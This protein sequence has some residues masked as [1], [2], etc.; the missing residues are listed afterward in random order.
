LYSLS[1]GSD[2]V[3]EQ[4]TFLGHYRISVDD[5]GAP[6]ERGRTGSAITYEATDERSGES[7][8]LTLIP[9]ASIDPA[10]QEQFEEQAHAATRI[11][12]VNIAKVF[13]FGREKEYFV[14]VAELLQGEPL[15]SWIAQHGPMP[16]D[17]V[18]RAAEQIVSVLSTARFHKLAHCAIQPSNLIIVPG[19]TPE[20]TWPFVK[21]LNFSLAGLKSSPESSPR[22]ESVPLADSRETDAAHGEFEKPNGSDEREESFS[23]ASQFASPEE[24]QHQTVDF[25]SEVYSLG[26]T[27]YFMLT[28]AVLPPEVRLR[29]RELSG[30]PKTL[31]DL[32]ANMLHRD[33]DRRPKDP[34]VLA[35]MIRGCL[36]KIERRQSLAR[37][38]GIPLAGVSRRKPRATLTPFAQVLRGI[39]VFASILLAAGVLGAFLLPADL[40]PFWHRTAAK[41]MI[42]VPIGVP[43]VSS[44]ATPQAVNAAPI[45]ANQPA[46]DAAPSPTE[47]QTPPPAPEQE[48]T[49]NAGFAAAT[50]PANQPEASPDVAAAGPENSAQAQADTESASSSSGTEPPPATASQSASSGKKKSV[51]SAT[52]RARV[53]RD[54]NYSQRRHSMR[55]TRARV[56]GIT[57]DGRLIFRLSS[58]RTVIVTPGSEDEDE[59]APSRRGRNFRSQARDQFFVPSRPFAPDYFPDD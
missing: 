45:V 4:T 15:A 40:N 3:M 7:V 59:V 49:S 37:R 42:G 50:T 22:E 58:G 20:G 10:A 44:L 39:L 53:T 51:A 29:S 24:L 1:A 6:H 14:Y 30:F 46:T 19:P 11:K 25:R 47:I 55:S 35:E 13:D 26:A 8:A 56:V 34:V 21:L 38:L 33:P 31:R 28:G 43:E 41:E 2:T 17:A 12:H 57:S 48:Q 9:V 18:L 27:M 16:A 52:K 32:I 5:K 54:S 23:G 36:L